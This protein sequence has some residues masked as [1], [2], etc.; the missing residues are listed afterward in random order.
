MPWAW[1]INAGFSVIGSMLSIILAQF[2]G[3]KLIIW[4]AVALYILAAICYKHLAD[5]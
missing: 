1:A 3:F 2:D 4:T 5:N